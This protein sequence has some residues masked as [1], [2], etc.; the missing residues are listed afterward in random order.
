MSPLKA[1]SDK[2]GFTLI[3]LMAAVTILAIVIAP[4]LGLFS[5]SFKNNRA[6][7]EKTVAVALAQAKIEE[8]KAVHYQEL[9]ALE[10]EP[11]EE[12][13]VEEGSKYSRRTEIAQLEPKLLEINVTVY[14]DGGEVSFSTL[15]GDTES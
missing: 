1:V 5:A 3:E 6:A 15:K 13:P 14:W 9:S 10:G 12:I 8:L 7:K 2:R 4:T 11:I